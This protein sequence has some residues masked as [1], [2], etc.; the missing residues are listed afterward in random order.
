MDIANDRQKVNVFVQ[1]KEYLMNENKDIVILSKCN[2]VPPSTSQV[3]VI[4]LSS[5]TGEGVEVLKR[6]LFLLPGI[7]STDGGELEQAREI[8]HP[9]IFITANNLEISGNV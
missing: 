7:I 2:V 6:L 1:L 8:L 9:Y 3:P 4:L 5:V